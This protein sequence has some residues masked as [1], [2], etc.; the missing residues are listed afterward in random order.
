MRTATMVGL[1]SSPIVNITVRLQVRPVEPAEMP[2]DATVRHY[3]EL[4]ESIQFDLASLEGNKSECVN[5]VDDFPEF[6]KFTRYYRFVECTS[7]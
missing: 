5:Y 1:T 2:A 6:V 4:D 7:A 3:D